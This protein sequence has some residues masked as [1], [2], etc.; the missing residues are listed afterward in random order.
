MKKTKFFQITEVSVIGESTPEKIK[1]AQSAILA[2]TAEKTGGEVKGD[3]IATKENIPGDVSLYH[4][5]GCAGKFVEVRS[6]EKEL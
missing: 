1:K 3:T 5:L 4:E 6:L 2:I